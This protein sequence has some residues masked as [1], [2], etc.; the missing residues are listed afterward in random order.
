[1]FRDLCAPNVPCEIAR[2]AGNIDCPNRR[3]RR[4]E[5]CRSNGADVSLIIAIAPGQP[6]R[7][8]DIELR[9]KLNQG[10]GGARRYRCQRCS[11]IKTIDLGR[12][13]MRKYDPPHIRRVRRQ[14]ATDA[15]IA[16]KSMVWHAPSQIDDFEI[17]K[18]A[19]MRR[20]SKRVC[21]FGQDRTRYLHKV[22]R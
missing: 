9:V 5:N 8:I 17:V 19:E 6:F 21:K 3:I 12:G 2:M 18:N 22:V 15:D 20:K 10:H 7:A 14:P 1:M 11:S 13:Q 4:V 16:H